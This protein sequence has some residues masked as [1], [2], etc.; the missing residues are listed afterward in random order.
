M[1]AFSFQIVEQ[2]LIKAP[3]RLLTPS[4]GRAIWG[5][6]EALAL[7]MVGKDAALIR[8]INSAGETVIRAGVRTALFSIESCHCLDCPLKAELR[9]VLSRGH[10]G[11]LDDRPLQ[12]SCPLDQSNFE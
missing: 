1:S 4:N 7:R 2:G 3:A 8:V 10:N 12:A 11:V 9:R 6:V 5:V